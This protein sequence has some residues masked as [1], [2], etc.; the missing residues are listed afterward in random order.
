MLFLM[1]NTDL[2]VSIKKQ[3]FDLNNILLGDFV[4]QDVFTLSS[5]SIN[6]L[7]GADDSLAVSLV[8]S[9]NRK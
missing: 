3:I 8:S 6:S 9:D 1:K 5:T 4:C 7:C 2:L